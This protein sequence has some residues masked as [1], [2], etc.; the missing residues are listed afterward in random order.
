MILLSKR[1]WEL[2]K[3]QR[4]SRWLGKAWPPRWGKGTTWVNNCNC[5]SPFSCSAGSCSNCGTVRFSDPFS[6]A[7]GGYTDP[8]CQT[9]GT[10][11]WSVASNTLT[12][13][14]TGTFTG[15]SPA[16][17]QT[18]TVPSLT[19]SFCISVCAHVTTR[20][21]V[22]GVTIGKG[23][24]AFFNASG[25]AEWWGNTAAS[26][27]GCITGTGTFNNTGD[28]GDHAGDWITLAITNPSGTANGYVH[29]VYRNAV[30]KFQHTGLTLSFG[31]TTQIGVTGQNGSQ[32]QCLYIATN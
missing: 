18:I 6:S 27:A 23:G 12:L 22:T 9:G 24:V 32:W 20:G 29:T 21:G 1:T 7:L 8:H 13:T 3:S 15:A 31:G 5:C 25:T 16:Y 17:T 10:S 2:E 28:A 4:I 26:A 19:S 30:Q 11:S 14:V